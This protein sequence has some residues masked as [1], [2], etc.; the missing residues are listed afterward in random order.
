[1]P[2]FAC[3][4]AFCALEGRSAVPRPSLPGMVPFAFTPAS[5]GFGRR[6]SFALTRPSH[7]PALLSEVMLSKVSMIKWQEITKPLKT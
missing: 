1:M 4:M 6:D 7:F 5:E 2:P 3:V